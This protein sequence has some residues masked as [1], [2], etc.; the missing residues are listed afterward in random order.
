MMS[1]L[2]LVPG[3]AKLAAA[4]ALAFALGLAVGHFRGVG[5]EEDRQEAARAVAITEAVVTNSGAVAQSAAETI[6]DAARNANLNE[7]LIN[8]TA[9]IPDS[10]PPIRRVRRACV[11]LREDGG[12]I[13]GMAECAGIEGGPP[14]KADGG[15]PPV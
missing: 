6:A 12:D 2:A 5:A 13:S 10:V 15:S 4:A 3:W 14:A 1:F 7:D 8:A 11:E 9:N